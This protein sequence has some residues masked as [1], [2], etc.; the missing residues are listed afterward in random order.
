MTKKRLAFLRVWRA[1]MKSKAE[2][3][4]ML[5]VSRG[6]KS[7]DCFLWFREASSVWSTH[8]HRMAQQSTRSSTRLA[9]EFLG[10]V[11]HWSSKRQLEKTVLHDARNEPW[12][13]LD[14]RHTCTECSLDS[15]RLR[16]C[17]LK[18]YPDATCCQ[19]P[20][21]TISAVVSHELDAATLGPRR[22]DFHQCQRFPRFQRRAIQHQRRQEETERLCK[23]S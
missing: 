8:K 13:Q 11:Y 20:L 2:I 21:Q 18:S 16:P 9:E 19:G 23:R 4:K 3:I 15:I 14:N 17:Q 5:D 10:Y 6:Q 22:W 12:L 7:S 1:F